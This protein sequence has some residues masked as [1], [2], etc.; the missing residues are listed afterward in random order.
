MFELIQVYLASYYTLGIVMLGTLLVGAT[1]AGIGVFAVLRRQSL[2]GDAISH[3][4][5]PGIALM[6]MGTESTNPFVLLLGGGIA[7]CIGAFL[8][9]VITRATT[10]KQ[11]ALLGIILSVFFGF[12]VVLKT[13]IQKQGLSNQALLGKFFFGNA[14]TLSP[15][16]VSAHACMALFIFCIVFLF[17]K[18]FLLISFDPD[19]AQALGYKVIM[20]EVALTIITVCAIVIGLHTVGVLLMSALLIAPAAAARQWSSTVTRMFWLAVFFGAFAAVVGSFVS[21][22][23]NH[24]PTGP[25][26]VVC[27]S[28]L[29]IL[30][31][32]CAPARGIGKGEL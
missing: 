12:G 4:A 30:T 20:L 32:M 29:V 19:F 23:I 22:R 26:I 18:E 11:D 6:F 24:L 15:F 21:S 16:D 7:G 5:L 2:L 13:V 25:T 8:V 17:W 14:S 28:V 1:A 3:A 10:L 31:F 27:M 9:V